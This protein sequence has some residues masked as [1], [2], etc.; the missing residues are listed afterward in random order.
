LQ[1][2]A[3]PFDFAVVDFPDPGNFSVGKLFTTAFYRK[4]AE[5]LAPGGAAVIQSTSPFVARKSFWCVVHTLEAA[6]L[7]ALPY[8]V[9][10][11]SFGEW[12]FVLAAKDT[13]GPMR[14]PPAGL[15]F[16]RAG[17][18][19]DWARFPPD[20]DEVPTEI[21]RLDNQ[22]LVRYFEAEWAPYQN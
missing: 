16:M 14:P 17:D 12:G 10:V 2:G 15:R 9:Y 6:G 7:R 8:H 19:A 3:G 20:M 1:H 21:N 18:L 13:L 11:P 4:L 22:A 5:A